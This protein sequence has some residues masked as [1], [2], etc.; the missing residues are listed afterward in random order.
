MSAA[1][2]GFV[3]FFIPTHLL[4]VLALGLL[5]GQQARLVIGN[6]AGVLAIGLMIGSIA[7]ASGM[8][9]KPAAII[10]LAVAIVAAASVVTARRTPPWTGILLALA[11]GVALPINSPP[12]EITIPAAVAS[13]AGFAVATLLAFGVATVIAM[14][15]TRPWQRIGLRI[16]GSWIAASAILVLALRLAR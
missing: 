4:A 16:V 15:A 8:R 9:E 6:A 7:I 12:H 2:G 1:L 10:L 11:T 5:A 14:G 3:Q 13:Q